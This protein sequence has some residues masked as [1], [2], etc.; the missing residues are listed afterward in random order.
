[1]QKKSKRA[2]FLGSVIDRLKSPSG[3]QPVSYTHRFNLWPLGITLQESPVVAGKPRTVEVTRILQPLP[4][5]I[6][7]VVHKVN[8]EPAQHL[9]FD[10]LV[11]LLKSKPLP[12]HVCSAHAPRPLISCC[13]NAGAMLF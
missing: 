3:P 11:D 12:F 5:Q 9:E 2:S 6:G 7:D 13:N 10:A 4:I 1:M 8:G